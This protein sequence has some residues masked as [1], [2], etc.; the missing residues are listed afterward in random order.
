M[1]GFAA[2]TRDVT[3]PP[4]DPELVVTLTMQRYAKIVDANAADVTVVAG[5]HGCH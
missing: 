1:R 3:I 4:N 5:D 2:V